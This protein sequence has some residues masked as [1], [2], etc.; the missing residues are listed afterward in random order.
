MSNII[1]PNEPKYATILIPTIDNV[2]KF[3]SAVNKYAC[4]AVLITGRYTIDAKSIMGVFSLDVTKP[5]TLRLDID[6]SKDD[7]E[8]LLNEIKEFIVEE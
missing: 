6:G 3:V 2:K 8:E 1:A 4:E 5:L 7:R